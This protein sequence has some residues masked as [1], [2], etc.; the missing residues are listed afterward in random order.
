MLGK[1][2]SQLGVIEEN[3]ANINSLPGGEI[4]KELSQVIESLSESISSTAWLLADI[5][6]QALEQE[7]GRDPLTRLFNRRFLQSVMQATIKAANNNSFPFSLLMCDIDQFK[8]INDKYGHVNGDEI[9]MDFGHFLITQT[10]ATDYVFRM[11]GDEFLIVLMG[12]NIEETTQIGEKILDNLK[13]HSFTIENNEP[14]NI[15]TSI[16][17]APYDGHPDYMRIIKRAD[18]A[19]YQAKNTGINSYF[20]NTQSSGAE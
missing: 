8:Q 4:K 15:T 5:S 11:G 19:L 18:K 7:S 16:G 10:R 3:I 12:V 20:I 6:N 17:A 1:L 14:I 13:T 9:L 2:K